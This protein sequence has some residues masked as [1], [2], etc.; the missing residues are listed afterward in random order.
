MFDSFCNDFS[1][2]SLTALHYAAR[3]NFLNIAKI[4]LRAG[5]N[6]NATSRSGATPL[7]RAAYIGNSDMCKLLMA[8]GADVTLVDERGHTAA[9]LARNN[10]HTAV[11]DLC[12]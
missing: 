12:H 2:V 6:V 5:A 4:L 1:F 3:C 9:D 8:H 10:A 11:A 7:H